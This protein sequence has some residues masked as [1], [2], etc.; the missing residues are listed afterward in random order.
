LA[1]ARLD[2]DVLDE[3]RKEF[4]SYICSIKGESMLGRKLTIFLA[5]DKINLKLR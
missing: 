2:I 3:R 4:V 5:K 1:E